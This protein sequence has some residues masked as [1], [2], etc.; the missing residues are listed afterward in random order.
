MP[1]VTEYIDA[2]GI[3]TTLKVGD[4]EIFQLTSKK[5][6]SN[7]HTLEVDIYKTSLG[8][9]CSLS[10]KLLPLVVAMWEENKENQLNDFYS[11]DNN[12][13]LLSHGCKRWENKILTV[14]EKHD[15]NLRRLIQHGETIKEMIGD[16]PLPFQLTI[17]PT[18]L[19][20]RENKL[21]D[22]IISKI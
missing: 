3:K 7:N 14:D 8:K 11:F 9:D 19:D 15:K 13:V 4:A 22:Y 20:L 16:F 5:E 21:K 10:S 18:I 12:G 2:P 6:F 1:L 17:H